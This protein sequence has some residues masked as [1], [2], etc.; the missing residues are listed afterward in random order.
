MAMSDSIPDEIFGPV[1]V[2]FL[3]EEIIELTATIAFE[4]CVA[5]FNR[6]LEIE[7]SAVCPV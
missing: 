1:R 2:H 6:A 7:W 3:E 5:K 4:I